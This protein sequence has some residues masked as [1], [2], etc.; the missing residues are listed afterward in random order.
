MSCEI[1]WLPSASRDVF[2]LRD[3]IK[4]NNPIAA[5]RAAKRIIHGVNVLQ[6]NPEAGVL[7]A[8]TDGFR[9]LMLPFGSGEYIIRYRLNS[10]GHVVIVRVRHS[11]EAN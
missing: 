4:E 5:Q 11:K 10:K 1:V 6:N 9:D 2:R 8:D 7:V 3:F